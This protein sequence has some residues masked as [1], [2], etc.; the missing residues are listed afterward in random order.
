MVMT[1][2]D[3]RHGHANIIQPLIDRSRHF[4]MKRPRKPVRRNPE[5]RELH[6]N[7]LYRS[8]IMK[9]AQLAAARADRWDRRAKHRGKPEP[10]T[11]PD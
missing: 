2:Y 10:A 1:R 8:K 5:A 6:H 3:V 4:R 7:P 9:S 11:E